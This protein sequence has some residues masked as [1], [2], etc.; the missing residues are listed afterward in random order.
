MIY[1][2]D[3]HSYFIDDLMR[4]TI[5]LVIGSSL[6][7]IGVLFLL[8]NL[9]LISG[10]VLRFW[11]ILLIVAGIVLLLNYFMFTGGGAGNSW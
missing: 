7:S 1:K 5:S 4:R 9:N 6:F 3:F 2:V 11:P 10:D 8:K